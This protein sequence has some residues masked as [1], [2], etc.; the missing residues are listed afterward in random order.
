MLQRSSEKNQR[1]H[2][3]QTFKKVFAQFGN[4]SCQLPQRRRESRAVYTQHS[5]DEVE[6]IH[7]VHTSA[8]LENFH[9]FSY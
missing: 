4:H 1:Q 7:R 6:G 8:K 3:E 2:L 9:Q 5:H